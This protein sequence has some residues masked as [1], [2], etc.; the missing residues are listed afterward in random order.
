[1]RVG[2]HCRGL[3]YDGGSPPHF[4]CHVEIPKSVLWRHAGDCTFRCGPCCTAL[5]RSL[6]FWSRMW[7][8]VLTGTKYW[9]KKLACSLRMT[10]PARTHYL[11]TQRYT[12][13]SWLVCQ[14][15]HGRCCRPTR[16][17]RSTR[18]ECCRGVRRCTCVVC[19]G[20]VP[21]GMSTRP[22]SPRSCAVTAPT[23]MHTTSCV[24]T[25]HYTWL[26]SMEPALFVLDWMVD[27][28]MHSL[29]I[30][31]RLF[32]RLFSTDYYQKKDPFWYFVVCYASLAIEH[33][34][35][36]HGKLI[37]RSRIWER[38]MIRDIIPSPTI[39]PQLVVWNL[40]AS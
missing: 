10:W 40:D 21:G 24:A 29:S 32:K 37:I 5:C 23:S 34:R 9:S 12:A 39:Y 2:K 11:I 26:Y 13:R 8:R 35:R 19:I 27:D 22:R 31:P 4:S 7:K 16:Q 38:D 17:P 18:G 3:R 30:T 20:E 36:F 28:I 6:R 14:R 1:M 15:R 25:R 33:P